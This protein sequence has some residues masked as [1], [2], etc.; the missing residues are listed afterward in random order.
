MILFL[1]TSAKIEKLF[2]QETEWKTFWV[3][4]M[5]GIYELFETN[6]DFITQIKMDN[7]KL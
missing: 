1:F 3:C 4:V 5:N 6:T 2:V 7:E